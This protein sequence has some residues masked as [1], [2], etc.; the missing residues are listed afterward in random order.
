MGTNRKPLDHQIS[1]LLAQPMGRRAWLAATGAVSLLAVAGCGST[2]TSQKKA[3][4][5]LKGGLLVEQIQTLSNSYFV[6]LNQGST[7]F[8]KAL[9]LKLKVLQHEG[10]S[11]LQLSQIKTTSSTAG[12]MLFGNV[13]TEGVLPAVAKACQSSSIYYSNLFDIPAWFTPPDVGKYYVAYYTQQNEQIAYDLAKILF[14]QMGGKGTFIHV[15]AIPG[16]TADTQRTAGVLRAVKEFPNIKRAVTAPGNWNETDARKVFADAAQAHPEFSG[17]FAQSDAMGLGVVSVL[18]Q[19]R[20][21][22]KILVGIDGD[23]DTIAN[24]TKGKQFASSASVA[25]W[26]GAFSAVAVFD[27]LNGWKPELPERMMYIPSVTITKDNAK[28]Y[29]DKFFKS[30]T[31]PFDWK[32][33]SRTLNPKSWNPGA[34][35][36][37]IEPEVQWKGIPQ[38]KYRLNDAY[39]SLDKD[40]FKK[41]ATMYEQHYTSGPYKQFEA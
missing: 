26:D 23:K 34:K 21:K 19:R 27:A 20:I 41:I 7:E 32:M 39:K 37:P 12:K 33:M 40:A 11:S 38:S 3:A 25:G 13:A 4:G 10:D 18:D 30:A 5:D 15:V 14:K 2:S 36:I 17:V 28:S 24:I 6:N 9:G 1:G 29:Y 31:L 22:N 35:V 16:A 8:A